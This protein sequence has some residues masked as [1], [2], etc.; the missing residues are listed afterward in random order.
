MP[1]GSL[2]T[3]AVIKPGPRTPKKAIILALA[4]ANIDLRRVTVGCM[5]AD[6]S[7]YSRLLVFRLN[8]YEWAESQVRQTLMSSGSSRIGGKLFRILTEPVQHGS[9]PELRV[10]RL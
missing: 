9:V 10:L 2:S 8:E 7:F 5:K 1:P 6:G 4:S 3:L